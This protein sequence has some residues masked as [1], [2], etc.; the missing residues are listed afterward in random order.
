MVTAAR[1]FVGATFRHRGRSENGMDCLGLVLL[2]LAAVGRNAADERLYQRDPEADGQK[3]RAA[4]NAHFGPLVRDLSAGCVVL[5]QWHQNPNH[6]ALIA[7]YPHGGFSVIHA[8]AH[9][10]RVVEQ[11]LAGPWPRRI[12]GVWRP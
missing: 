6:V 12:R 9:E 2:S 11:R 7:D 8:L 10:K 3:L 5:M 1:G 4:L